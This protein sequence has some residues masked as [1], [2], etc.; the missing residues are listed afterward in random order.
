MPD[1]V[2]IGEASGKRFTLPVDV[3]TVTTAVLGIRGS[4]KSHT[5]SVV[6]EDLLELGCQVVVIDPTDVWW[7]LR[8]SADGKRPGRSIVVCGGPHGQL[9]LAEAD[10]GSFRTYLSK[11]RSNGLIEVSGNVIRLTDVLQQ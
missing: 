11:L 7:G 10:G 9:P 1:R 2:H 4:G 3:Q 6:V 8:S 5:A